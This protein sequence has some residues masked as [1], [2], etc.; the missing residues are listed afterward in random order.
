MTIVRAEGPE[1]FVNSKISKETWDVLTEEVERLWSGLYF[2]TDPTR[3]GEA[4]SKEDGFKLEARVIFDEGRNQ[5]A[6]HGYWFEVGMYGTYCNTMFVDMAAATAYFR[7]AH[8]DR[9]AF[10]KATY[11]EV[12]VVKSERRIKSF[13]GLEIAPYPACCA[14]YQANGF[15]Y[16]PKVQEV[17]A[18]IMDAF[19]YGV[20]HG[21][22]HRAR[23]LQFNFVEEGDHRIRHRITRADATN[24]LPEM[25]EELVERYMYFPA[26]YKWAKQ[27]DAFQEL[28]YPNLNSGN[29]IHTATFMPKIS[30]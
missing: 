4:W 7:L 14:M 13:V 22:S 27:Q 2:F 11:P 29:I 18:E 15:S 21:L 6:K 25:S 12:K 16:H 5:Y 8:T 30:A 17:V 1:E 20:A 9:A 10:A 19:A 28:V 24:P 3:T 23:R 26:I